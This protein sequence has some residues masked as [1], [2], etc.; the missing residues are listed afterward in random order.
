MPDENGLLNAIDNYSAQSYGSGTSDNGELS[1]QRSLA[2][3]AYAGKMLDVP[4]KGRSKVND[5]TVFETVQWIMPSMMRIFAGGENVVEFEP[6]GPEDEEIAE[7]ESDYLNYMVTQRNDWDL[8]VREWC[9]DGLTTK[10][11]YC[12]VDME[13]K[14]IPEIETYEGQSEDQLVML[15]EDKMEIVGQNQYDDPDRDWE[16]M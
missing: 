4:P 13:E 11:A 2:L 16:T 5:R 3:D 12:L 1:R 10:N 14:I 9:Q 15:V 7:Q 8:T 6:V